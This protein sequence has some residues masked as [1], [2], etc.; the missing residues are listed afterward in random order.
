[1]NSGN[2]NNNQQP[3]RNYP[4]RSSSENNLTNDDSGFKVLSASIFSTTSP[5]RSSNVD[6]FNHTGAGSVSANIVQPNPAARPTEELTRHRLVHLLRLPAPVINLI[7][8]EI[9]TRNKRTSNPGL[10][11]AHGALS[12]DGKEFLIVAKPANGLKPCLVWYGSEGVLQHT[13]IHD[14]HLQD[15][16]RRILGNND[17]RDCFR[18]RHEASV[19]GKGYEL[20]IASN[21]TLPTEIASPT[22]AEGKKHKTIKTFDKH[23][24]L[25]QVDSSKLEIDTSAPPEKESLMTLRKLM[26]PLRKK[27]M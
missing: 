2:I 9:N 12:K 3:P 24:D 17:N 15:D 22:E 11:L 1:M 25:L 23:Y 10:S 18:V 20:K 16:D 7:F 21:G 5:F 4:N 19:G 13:L 8:Q 27:T 14:Q 26:N 6:S